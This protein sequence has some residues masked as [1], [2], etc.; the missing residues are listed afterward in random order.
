[1]KDELLKIQEALRDFSEGKKSKFKKNILQS[2][3][4]LQK[5][6][7]LEET[8]LKWLKEQEKTHRRSSKIYP[9]LFRIYDFNIQ[10]RS[11]ILKKELTW[12]NQIE[13]RLNN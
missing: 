6:V 12:L 7:V 5:S 2:K 9:E 11:K 1:M 8:R 10:E 3:D 13:K 4:E